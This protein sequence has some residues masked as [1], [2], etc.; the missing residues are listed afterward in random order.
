MRPQGRPGC[1]LAGPRARGPCGPLPGR[2]GPADVE[3]PTALC[4]H[5]AAGGGGRGIPGA[6][7]RVRVCV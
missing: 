6:G 1:G 7:A 2:R 4:G 3:Q 5:A